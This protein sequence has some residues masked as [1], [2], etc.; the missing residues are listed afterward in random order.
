MTDQVII[1]HV[2][3]DIITLGVMKEDP[4]CEIL[5]PWAR[6]HLTN[7]DKESMARQLAHL[8]ATEPAESDEDKGEQIFFFHRDYWMEMTLQ[9]MVDRGIDWTRHPR[10]TG[11]YVE[12]EEEMAVYYYEEDMKYLEGLN[13]NDMT[14]NEEKLVDQI[15]AIGDHATCS[16]GAGDFLADEDSVSIS[17]ENIGLIDGTVKIDA[18]QVLGKRTEWI[19]NKAEKAGIGKAVIRA[20]GRKK[21]VGAKGNGR[22]F[23]GKTPKYTKL[24]ESISNQEREMITRANHEILNPGPLLERKT[25]QHKLP[26]CVCNPRWQDWLRPLSRK[27]AIIHPPKLE[28][29]DGKL[30]IIKSESGESI[31]T[32]HILE[33]KETKV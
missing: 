12:Q 24:Q 33:D 3:R 16:E 23:A 7:R 1:R 8:F 17:E 28:I 32:D 19:Y 5:P 27:N 4:A 14:T 30:L 20:G 25:K 18:G 26:C 31:D 11:D 22:V 29:R 13:P 9:F 21:E 10:F 6:S 15:N 2:P